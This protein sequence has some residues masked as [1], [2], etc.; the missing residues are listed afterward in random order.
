MDNPTLTSE[1]QAILE[2]IAA[3][4]AVILPRRARIILGW[5]EGLNLEEIAAEVGLT[6]RT[7]RKWVRGFLEQGLAI[8]PEDVLADA[9]QAIAQREE[10]P[11][12]TPEM[13]VEQLCR[14]HQVDMEHAVHVGQLARELFDLTQSLHELD[15][16][17]RDLIYYAGLL[18]N[19]AYAG[20]VKGHH[21][22]G[23]DI[24]LGV[25]LTDLDDQDRFLV[26]VAAAFHRKR[27]KDSR[28]ET[29]QSYT[30][31]PAELQPVAR[32]LSALVRI[33]DGLDY[34]QSQTTTLGPTQI[35]SEGCYITAIGPFVNIDAPRA[36]QKA[37]MW[38]AVTGIPISIT[39][40]DEAR[41][42]VRGDT[43]LKVDERPKPP[44]I[45]PDDPM[46]E[47]GRKILRFHLRRMLYHEPGTRQGDDI[48]A[49]HDM[50]VATR[51]MRAALRV[52]GSYFESET[53]DWIRK[54]VQ[55]IGQALGRVRDLDVLMANAQAHLDALP[56]E[57]QYELDPLLE[58]WRNRRD[59][60]RT[61]MLA[62]LD[63]QAYVNF[64][65][66]FM[67]FCET[68]GMGSI[69]VSPGDPVPVYVAHVVPG[70][71]Y[72]RYETVRAYDS[73]LDQAPISTLHALRIDA[74]RMRYTLEFFREVLS[75]EAGDVIAALIHVQD[76]L[77]A[78][79]D[80]DVARLLVWK[81][82]EQRIREVR[83]QQRQALTVEELPALE[84][85]AAYLGSR[86]REMQRLR[87]TFLEVWEDVVSPEMRLKLAQ[88]VSVL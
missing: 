15:A 32:W 23:R 85:I 44:Q 86:E 47:A 78:L 51:R 80:A 87:E 58:H 37:D 46:S 60:A 11:S 28:L 54:G 5:N 49:L 55:R 72:T 1:E 57:R 73:V 52:F 75:T 63:S 66:R 2:T 74:K 45:Q 3:G 39:T 6:T 82:L 4:D 16:R 30:A 64:A 68:P 12:P 8:F 62:H 48:E 42:G 9:E 36:D 70:M 13:T 79:H 88:A 34:S 29:E 24:L 27:W 20:G 10:L 40:E 41:S 35:G 25:T 26:A 56:S 84:G 18:H 50:R 19:V 77:G 71:I 83:K 14:R 31:L 33:A 17:Y 67:T 7:V 61:K 76:H 59:K 21:K 65:D 43:R 53:C 22:R 69:K 38:Q 81:Y